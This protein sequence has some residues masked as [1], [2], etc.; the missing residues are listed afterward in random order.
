MPRFLAPLVSALVCAM[1]AFA[2]GAPEEDPKLG[3]VTGNVVE[4]KSGAPVG[5]ALVLLRQGQNPAAGT[6]TD[7]TGK[8]AL[9]N[10]EPGI[11]SVAVEKDGWVAARDSRT[12]T[13]TVT[14]GQTAPT[15]TLKLLITAAISGRV[16]DAD[17]DSISGV[18]IQVTPEPSGKSGPPGSWG[19]TNDRGEYRAFNVAPGQYRVCATYAARAQREDVR[20]QPGATTA[21]PRVCYPGTPQG[22]ILTIESGSEVQGVDFQLVPARAVKVKGRVIAPPMEGPAVAVVNLR[23]ADSSPGMGPDK[24][25]IL[26]D[27]TGSFEIAGV[28]PGRYRL[29][30]TGIEIGGQSRTASSKLI[31]V[32]DTDLEGVEII[33]G[34]PRAIEGRLVVPEGRKTPPLMIVLASRDPDN[35]Q[36]GGIAHVSP[37]GT[38]RFPSVAAGEYDVML[39]SMGPGDD[40]YVSAI[41][42]GASDALADGVRTDVAGDLEIVLKE[43][44][45]TLACSVTGEK[46]EPVSAGRVVLI[47]DPPRE[48]QRALMGGCSTDARGACEILG[49]TPGEYHV[50]AYP[51]EIVIDQRDPSAFKPFE[52]Y[53]KAVKIAEGERRDIQLKAAPVE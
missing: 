15:L 47:P 20:M 26:R 52:K 25:A 4:S 14:A 38:F 35:Y 3:R 27:A 13:A 28:L 43:H 34:P 10:L 2:Q 44:G 12:L 48:R 23:P 42:L 22:N 19:S 40:L 21:Y 30:V 46:D 53:G 16:V 31:E 37:A 49:V 41:R 29:T 6:F 50:Y 7:S 45:G 18:S 39:G 8:F 32:G 24:N 5:K 17:G 9:R 1:A 36:A 51:M 33:L 11:Y